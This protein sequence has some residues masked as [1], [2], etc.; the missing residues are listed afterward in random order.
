[1]DRDRTPAYRR[2]MNHRLSIP[3][4][5]FASLDR[6]GWIRSR[7]RRLWKVDCEGFMASFAHNALKAVR[8]W[9][10]DRTPGTDFPTTTTGP[11]NRKPL[12]SQF[13]IA[14]VPAS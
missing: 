3:E 12:K 11:S 7:L 2:E 4:G 8:R 5:T 9:A 1:M 10:R 13:R 6:L 14:F